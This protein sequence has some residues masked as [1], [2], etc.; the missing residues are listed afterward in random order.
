[1]LCHELGFVPSLKKDKENV[2]LSVLF[3]IFCPLLSLYTPPN[4]LPFP[5][6]APPP[7]LTLACLSGL[8]PCIPPFPVWPLSQEVA[9]LVDK[10]HGGDGEE[11]LDYSRPP[12]SMPVLCRQNDGWKPG[13]SVMRIMV[14][15]ASGRP[16]NKLIIK[17]PKHNENDDA[18]HARLCESQS[19][20]FPQTSR[21]GLF[22]SC[23]LHL[24]L[25]S[26]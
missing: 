25:P 23:M 21:S 18:H 2:C 9:Q 16:R 4:P 19:N 24:I 10:H 22:K 14:G 15:V 6:A 20:L 7:T 12:A 1:M 13:G 11:G 8:L 17:I 5:I 3:S 26:K